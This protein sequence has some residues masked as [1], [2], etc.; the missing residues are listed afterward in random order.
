MV[1]Q[2]MQQVQKQTQT[3]VLAPQLRQSLKILQVPALELRNTI[4]EELQTNP[5][6]E[7]LP[8]EGISIEDKSKGEVEVEGDGDGDGEQSS[9]KEDRAKELEFSDDFKVLAQID[10][11]SRESFELENGSASYSSEAAQRRQYFWDSLTTETSLQEHL[12]RQA[13]LAESTPE[14]MEG[15]EYLIGSLDNRGYLTS[16][17][18]D[19][20]LNSNLSLKTIQG[21]QKLLKTLDP[22]GIGSLDLKDCLL[23]QLD[24]KGK[25][26]SPAAKLIKNHLDLLLR[27]RIPDIARKM[28]ISI[29]EVQGLLEEISALDPVPGRK[30]SEDT[31]RIVQPDVKVE[32]DDDEWV[33]TLN[34][35]YIP[36]L[37][38][39]GTYKDLLAKGKLSAQERDYIR[40]KIKSGKF[41]ISSIEQRQNTIE[42]ITREILNMQNEFF[43][44][45]LSH[46]RPLTMSQVADEVGVHETTV[47]RA[48][49]N[50]YIETPYGV[51]EF[52][53]FFTTGYT[54]D[55]GES[56]ANTTVK[57][58]IAKIIESEP[59]TKPYSDQSIVNILQEREVTI[60]RRTVAKYREEL[61][62]L[63]TN[64]R[65]QYL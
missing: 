28:G 21:A 45:G 51:F 1:Y 19:I 12:I 49:A 32:K 47:S 52:K 36:K 43:E 41:L 18:S 10:E 31:N 60:A 4:L 8:M 37:R 5:A 24:I 33:I 53:Y 13:E 44:K 34:N 38:L 46:L 16:S 48:L 59:P 64:L 35:E 56:I 3:L 63:P 42:R 29:D 58:S 65:R 61:G 50:K 30:F 25:G 7:E 55:D 6:L 23:T 17:L 20:A 15:V 39:S 11:V 40:E 57:E 22:P 62:I 9:S 26:K 2:G 27:R 54:R 14:I